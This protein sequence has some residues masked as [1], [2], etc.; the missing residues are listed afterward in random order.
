MDEDEQT[1]DKDQ[2]TGGDEDTRP[3]VAR[4]SPIV[5]NG[6]RTGGPSLTAPRND[7]NSED[8]DA[9]FWKTID[10][11][12]EASLS[13]LPAAPPTSG[14]NSSMDEDEDMWDIAN[15]IERNAESTATNTAEITVASGPLPQNH[16]LDDDLDDMYE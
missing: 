8:D 1:Q 5:V 4:S 10:A 15:E 7:G 2:N 13:D 16:P 9:E 12:M 3:S 6:V 14:P 11:A